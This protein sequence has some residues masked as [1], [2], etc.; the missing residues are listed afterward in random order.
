MEEQN[1]MEQVSESTEHE[2]S[3]GAAP[4]ENG[5]QLTP[6]E[7]LDLDKVEKFKFQGKEWNPKDFRNSYLM[8]QDYTKKTQ[9]ISQERKFVSNLQYDLDNVKND[10]SL[11]SEFKRVYPEKFHKFLD[12]V[13]SKQPDNVQRNP[14]MD[15]IKREISEFRSYREE[16]AEQ[17]IEAIQA[18]LDSKFSK[19]SEKY[20]FA[21]E[22]TVISKAQILLERLK[23]DQGAK[24]RI[25]D[26]Q[27]DMLWKSVH[28]RNKGIADKNYGTKINKQQ[29]ANLKGRDVP[30]GGGI[31]GHAPKK[32]RTIKEASD[33]ALEELMQQ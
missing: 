23:D 17:K 4:Q 31:P 18:E 11:A 10:P 9:E 20:T 22:D 7:I 15:E 30:S 19:L 3:E 21:D 26:A 24:A 29:Q 16:L 33:F 25:T 6:Q 27:W 32:P 28:D 5:Q 2:G 14:E 1:T 13:V 8:H 12:Y